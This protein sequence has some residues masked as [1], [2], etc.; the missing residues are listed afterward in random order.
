MFLS[1]ALMALFA[2]PCSLMNVRD[3]FKNSGHNCLTYARYL[4]RSLFT[5]QFEL[6]DAFNAS[7]AVL[8][9]QS[10]LICDTER[11]RSYDALSKD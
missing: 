5:R 3:L 10:P 7:V 4:V 9:Q 8:F 6:S 2:F 11:A 1:H